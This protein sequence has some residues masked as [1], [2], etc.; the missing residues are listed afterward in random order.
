[1]YS[2][3]PLLASDITEYGNG[4][5]LVAAWQY[6]EDDL[7]GC[8]MADPNGMNCGIYVTYYADQ[9]PA[10]PWTFQ[11]GPNGATLT[12]VD[13]YLIGDCFSV[14]DDGIH[15]GDTSIPPY[16]PENPEHCGLVYSDPEVCLESNASKGF[17]ELGFG[18][19]SITMKEI[20]DISYA[21]TVYFRIDGDIVG[22]VLEVDIDVQPKSTKNNVRLSTNNL[23]PV[24][25]MGSS[26]YDI[27]QVDPG[28]VTFEGASPV[29]PA[30]IKDINL[31]GMPDML[32]KF[33]IQAT[34]I[35]CGD[36]E[37]TLSGQTWD[38]VDVTGTDTINTVRCE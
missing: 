10:P 33:A 28:S 36:T 30:K 3:P 18:D 27:S 4:E 17:F 38:G 20:C 25:I 19:H 29:R 6:G 1:M 2:S 14:Y 12:V 11:V 5:W 34:D 35:E 37:A 9:A 15:I 22:A 23:L 16:D 7:V 21:G 31:D 13:T 8:Q 24:A 26:V 32:F